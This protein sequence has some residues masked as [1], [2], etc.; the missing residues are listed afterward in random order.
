MGKYNRHE[1]QQM[2]LHVL[3][4]KGENPQYRLFMLKM[5]KHTGMSFESIDARITAMAA[6]L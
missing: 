3:A 4:I 6:G 5:R 1:L 2:A